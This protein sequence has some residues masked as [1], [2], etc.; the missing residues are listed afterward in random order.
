[1]KNFLRRLPVKIVC[2][3]L[4]VSSLLLCA[5]G[6]FG[7]A[8]FAE[9]DYYT[10]SESIV[11]DRLIRSQMLSD[12]YSIARSALYGDSGYLDYTADKSSLRYVVSDISGKTVASNFTPNGSENWE[13]TFNVCVNHYVD[14]DIFNDYDIYLVDRKE[15]IGVNQTSYV[16]KVYIA[17]N[18]ELIDEYA[19]IKKGVSLTYP[20]KFWIYPIT[21]SAF[22][23]FVAFFCILMCVSARRADTEELH[24][25]Y[26]HRIPFDLMLVISVAG[27]FLSL[28][29][30]GEIF[31]SEHP[32]V[33]AVIFGA[34]GL[35]AINI[36]IG[37]CM[38]FAA[39]IKTKTLISN[40]LVCRF[41]KL[42]IRALRFIW[43][44]V[45][46]VFRALKKLF[47][48]L[49]LIWRTA[50][51]VSAYVFLDFIVVIMIAMDPSAIILWMFLV[52][53]LV[54][55]ALY[56]ALFMRKLQ[57]GGNALAKGDLSFKTDT[58]MMFWDF[59]K[60]GENLNSIV[61]GMAIA[62]EERLQSERTKAELIT[63]VSHDI[64]TPLTSIINYAGLISEEE[65]SCENH[66]E[67]SAVLVRK[68]EHLKRLLED[69]VEISKATTGNLEITLLPCDAG[70]LLTQAAGEFEHKCEV[71]GLELIVSR[72][73]QSVRINADSRRI[74]RV[75]ENLMNNACKYSLGGSRVFLSLETDG[76][77]AS[78]VFRNT[79]KE[80]ITVSPG[81][82][83]ERFVRGDSS[84]TSDGNGLGLSIAK[85]LT[86]LQNGT[87]DISIDGDLFKVTLTFP[88]I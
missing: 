88:V 18:S 37:L 41:V 14:Y 80:I 40:T 3:V 4:C 28:V 76:K 46:K 65:C 61:D 86:E 24:P 78:F 38:S 44:C 71:A 79:S 35:A 49:P 9:L 2:F 42:C 68:S 81:E 11:T 12:A 34:I 50:V 53:H 87:M 52:A 62:V 66:K 58:R 57:E 45:R 23:L 73:E 5:F 13:Y 17:E 16:I 27:V 54:A 74:W 60:H 20:L 36:F 1:M 67:Y 64:K 31:Y 7:A 8:A 25:G 47:L 55:A 69:L 30:A 72:P 6:A 43:R 75:F 15:N 19:L 39:R 51:I 63:N 10:S 33:F 21:I 29:A 48:N 56:S 70:V 82:L 84:R 85:S 26:F 22:L 59:K 32:V 83:T 77:N